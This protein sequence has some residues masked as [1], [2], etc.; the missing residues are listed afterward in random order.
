[1]SETLLNAVV[2]TLKAEMPEL[3]TAGLDAA[4]TLLGTLKD[5]VA[6]WGTLASAGQLTGEELQW[7]AAARMDVVRMQALEHSGLTLARFDE[8]RMR[9]LGNLVGALLPAASVE[10]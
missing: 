4:R 8:L 6:R 7:L 2:A 9:V 5:D 1:M 10:R 3:S